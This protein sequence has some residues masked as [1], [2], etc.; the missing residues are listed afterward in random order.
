MSNQYRNQDW[1]EIGEK[2]QDII[3][4]AINSQDY[5]RLSQTIRQ[6]VYKAVD[7]GGRVIRKA[8]EQDY[9]TSG[10]NTRRPKT[11]Y[12]RP[13]IVDAVPDNPQQNLPVLYG[14]TTGKM[15][16][17]IFKTIGGGMLSAGTAMSMAITAFVRLFLTGGSFLSFPVALSMLGFGG[18]I[19]LITDGVRDITRMKRFEKYLKMLGQKTY[20]RLDQLARSVGKSTPYVKKELQK[21]IRD[22]MFLEGHLDKEETCLITSNETYRNYEQSRLQL[23]A[24]KRQE[25]I[26]EQNRATARAAANP[27]VQEVLDKGNAFLIQIRRCNDAIPGEEISRKISRME[28]IVQRIFERAEAHP[29]IVPDLKKLM[30]YYLPM[31]VK[32]LNAYAEMDKQPIQGETIRS[33]KQEIEA[34]LDTLNTAFERLLDS[35]FKETALDVSSDISV[36]QT[37]LAQEGLTDDGLGD[38]RRPQGGTQQR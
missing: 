7:T 21:M 10:A 38:I 25:A 33:S 37:L 35:V 23:E 19:F 8:M 28:N 4:Q 29:E 15:L 18:G 24:R 27:Q 11:N 22:G 6:T 26:A 3:D 20:C 16:A 13:I 30:D 31:T 14:S 36:L 32:L 34:T 1:D 9:P 17:G 12:N 2:L 5:A